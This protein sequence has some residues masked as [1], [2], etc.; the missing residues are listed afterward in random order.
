MRLSKRRDSPE[1]R[2]E[3]PSKTAVMASRR[4]VALMPSRYTTAQVPGHNFKGS[5]VQ[6]RVRRLPKTK[7]RDPPTSK[8][9]IR[10]RFHTPEQFET[11]NAKTGGT[12]EE[13]WPAAR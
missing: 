11:G 7:T 12:S 4:I 13:R 6:V 10:I 3:N 9:E 2:S 1:Q 8:L 5:S